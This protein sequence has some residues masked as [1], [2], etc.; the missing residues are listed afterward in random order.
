M[1]GETVLTGSFN[2]TKATQTRNAENLLILRDTALA[3]QSTRNWE[4]HRSHSQPYVG[5]GGVR[6]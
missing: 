6:P 3:T 1:D 2:F 5:L 4:A